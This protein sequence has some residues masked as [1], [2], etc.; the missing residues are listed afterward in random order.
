MM[1]E[2]FR[3]KTG[4]TQQHHTIKHYLNIIEFDLFMNEVLNNDQL[5]AVIMKCYPKE[6][7][8]QETKQHWE[9]SLFFS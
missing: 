7:L 9:V 1:P 5:C 2:D 3:I 6:E 4:N 8:W